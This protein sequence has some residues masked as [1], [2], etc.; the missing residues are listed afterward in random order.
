VSPE[1]SQQYVRHTLRPEWGVG[2]LVSKTSDSRTYLFADGELRSIKEAFCQRVIEA[3]PAPES[4][5][6]RERLSRGLTAGGKATPQAIHLELEEEILRRPD[7]PGA[8]LVYADWLQ[9]RGDPR[10]ELITLQHQLSQAPQ[11]R[12]L[13]QAESTLLSSH[14]EYLVPPLL[15]GML[16]QPHRK[17]DLA[18]SRS[19]VTWR[20]GFFDAVRVARRSAQQPEVPAILAELLRH[21]SAHFLRGLTIGPLGKLDEYDYRAVVVAIAAAAPKRLEELFLADFSPEHVALPFSRLGDASPLLRSVSSLKRLSLRGGALRFEAAL[22]HDGLR[23]LTVTTTGLTVRTGARLCRACLPAL[24]RLEIDCPS[25]RLPERDLEALL[26]AKGFPKLQRLALRQTSAT[27]S[28]LE[29]ILESS[30]LPRLEKLELSEGDLTDSCAEL[31]VRHGQRLKHLKLL[32]LSANR[33]TAAAAARLAG[34]CAEVR[35]QP[36]LWRNPVTEAQ[37][38]SSSPDARSASLAREL[39]HVDDWLLLFRDGDR[40]WGEYEGSDHY[41]VFADMRTLRAGCTCPSPK[42]PCKHALGLLL[43]AA[44]QHELAERPMPEGLV[45]RSQSRPRYDPVWE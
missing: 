8:Y 6:A 24:E 30:L 5:E 1:A 38:L 7:D 31:L 23:E 16:A 22:E 44:S 34:L 14:G 13:L 21:P 26:K 40:V 35:A 10:G 19:E 28:L 29:A 27:A 20:L 33:L 41:E 32:D 9:A 36:R 18:G 39:A 43:I 4:A 3:A 12:S 25:L 17:A 15:A 37:V 2:V 45:A 42:D 11:R